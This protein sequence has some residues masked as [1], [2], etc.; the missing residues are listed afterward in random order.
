MGRGLSGHDGGKGRSE[1]E[2]VRKISRWWCDGG[3]VGASMGPRRGMS[4]FEGTS[5]SMTRS[6]STV[7][8]RHIVKVKE[9][10]QEERV[11]VG[12]KSVV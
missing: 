7:L 10:E 11:G 2:A 8:S 1:P 6:S 5:A 3:R 12:G 4:K 9:Q